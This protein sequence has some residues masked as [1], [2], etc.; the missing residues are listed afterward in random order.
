MTLFLHVTQGCAALA[1]G[2]FR[3]LPTGADRCAAHRMADVVI[4]LELRVWR[5]AAE[6]HSDLSVTL[7]QGFLFLGIL[8]LRGAPLLQVGQPQHQPNQKHAH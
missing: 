5:L 8:S 4:H 6:S 1:L 7:R 2:Y 3:W